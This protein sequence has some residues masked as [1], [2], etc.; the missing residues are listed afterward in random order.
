MAWV[1]MRLAL[2]PVFKEHAMPAMHA[3]PLTIEPEAEALAAELGV[4]KELD[5]IIDHARRTITGLQCLNVKFAPAYDTGEEGIIIEAIRDP[6]SPAIND[7][8]WD[9]SSDWKLASFSPDVYRHITLLD[10]FG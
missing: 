8:T 2:A 9:Q 4:Q 5:Q 10:E 6:A 1:T 3:I 7:W